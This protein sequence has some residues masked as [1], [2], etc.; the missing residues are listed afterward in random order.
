M[1]PEMLAALDDAELERFRVRSFY[2]AA[3]LVSEVRDAKT[4]FLKRVLSEEYESEKA[5][6]DAYLAEEARRRKAA[7]EVP[8]GEG[9]PSVH[10]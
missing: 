4:S 8:D 2:R 3:R 1:T 9:R 5:T 10:A 7:Q 6:L